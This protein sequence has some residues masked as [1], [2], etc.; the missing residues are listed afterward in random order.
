MKKRMPDKFMMLFILIIISSLNNKAFAQ[1]DT[2]AKSIVK[3]QY[4]NTNNSIQYLQLESTF[5]KN[6]ISSPQQNKT[7]ALFLDSS[8]AGTFIGKAVTGKDGK[9]FILLPPSLKNA[10]DGSPQHTFIVKAGNDELI[11]DYSIRK[12][13]LKLDTLTI[14][15]VRNIVATVLKQE[16]NGWIPAGEVELKIGIERLGSILSAGDEA[17]YTTDSTGTVSVELKKD[18]MPGDN[19]GNYILAARVEDNDQLGNL[20]VEKTVPWGKVLKT[21]NSFFNQRNLWT[22]RFRT[23]YWL[24]FMAYGIVI[25]VWGTILYLV[26]Q[27]IKI[28]KLGTKYAT[29]NQ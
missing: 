6:K 5:K 13:K 10:W 19:K 2:A 25:A 1:E 4:Y 7:Y 8:H 21:D 16:N 15:G 18:S 14:D 22:T 26:V 12:S 23:P 27:I 17:T 28:K 24:L 9:A 20:L 29:N 11:S 3:L